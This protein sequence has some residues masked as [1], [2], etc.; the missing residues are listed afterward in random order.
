VT[1]SSEIGGD[2]FSRFRFQVGCL[3]PDAFLPTHLV[4]Y[5]NDLKSVLE[6]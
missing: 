3:E 2:V 6:V 5:L 4:G 1:V